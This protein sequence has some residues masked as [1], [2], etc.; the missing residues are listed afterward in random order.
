MED[1]LED[2]FFENSIYYSLLPNS[3]ASHKP[4]LLSKSWLIS[5]LL[6]SI[7]DKLI[8]HPPVFSQLVSSV[9]QSSLTLCNLMDWSMLGLL[10]HHHSR[11][12]LKLIS[13]DS[14]M[15]SN[16]L[17]LCHPLLPP[18]IFPSIRVF[19]NVSVLCIRWLKFWSFSFS[20]SPSSEFSGLISFR[21]D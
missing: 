10:V 11:S 17:I 1:T 20:I 16:N 8:I 18:S 13:I 15:P 14:V 2:I 21:M 3:F 4:T 19:S 9:T 7:F 12:L 6:F 5:S